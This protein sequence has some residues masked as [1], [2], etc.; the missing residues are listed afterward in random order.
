MLLLFLFAVVGKKKE[1]EFELAM[2]YKLFWLLCCMPYTVLYRIGLDWIEFAII[3]LHTLHTTLRLRLRRHSFVVLQSL[4]WWKNL[5]CPSSKVMDSRFLQNSHPHS[6]SPPPT[7]ALV[8][9]C[10]LIFYF[11][12][13]GS[14]EWVVRWPV[15][16][17]VL[18]L[19]CHSCQG[20]PPSTSKILMSSMCFFLTLP[21]FQV[22]A[23]T[24]HE[25]LQNNSLK[26]NTITF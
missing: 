13:K 21:E 17:P 8:L 10:L 25:I 11:R 26:D 6:H 19:S 24:W 18:L 5:Y 15:P 7:P 4:E 9:I 20:N 23:L 12:E 22:L 2:S 14:M 3:L 16:V 1:V